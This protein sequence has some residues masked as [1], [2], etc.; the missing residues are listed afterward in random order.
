[1]RV[2]VVNFCSTAIDMLKFSTEM[3]LKN[4]GTSDFDYIV[5]TWNPSNEVM[6]YIEARPFIEH[7]SYKTNP[8][9]DYIPNLRAMMNSGWDAGYALNDYVA[10][11]NTDMAFG[12]DWLL[13]LAKHTSED[14][15]PNSLHITPIVG[16]H[17][18]TKDFGIPTHATFNMDDFNKLHDQLYSDKIET[19]AERGGWRNCATMPYIVHRKWWDKCGPWRPQHIRGESSPDQQFFERVHNAGAKYILVYDSICYHHEAVERRTSRPV[20]IER[21]PE[22]K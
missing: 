9:L 3:L 4:A 6:E 12:R 19:E 10:I 16:P 20:G 15:I 13:N 22:G 21:M 18:V 2:S 8:E 5:V 14:V 11:V 1:M 17:V 7:A